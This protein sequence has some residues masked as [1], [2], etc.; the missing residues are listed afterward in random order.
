MQRIKRLITAAVTGGAVGGGGAIAA[1][2]S[3]GE[4]ALSTLISAIVLAVML[5]VRD[6]KLEG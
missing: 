4:T 2:A 1:N 6:R 3:D 5:Y